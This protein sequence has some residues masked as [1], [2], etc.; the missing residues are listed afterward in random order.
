MKTFFAMFLNFDKLPIFISSSEN[1]MIQVSIK[2]YGIF[3]T[4]NGI[5]EIISLYLLIPYITDSTLETPDNL[6]KIPKLQGLFVDNITLDDLRN[7]IAHSFVTV[8]EFKDDGT[9]HGKY[10]VFDDR[11]VEN[12]KTHSKKGKHGTCYHVYIDTI[13]KRLK[14]LF[15][16]VLDS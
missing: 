10:L 5:K 12:K 13:N 7:A 11:I 4:L 1:R 9:E 16:E 14:E 15:K 3:E 2:I 6:C 8:E